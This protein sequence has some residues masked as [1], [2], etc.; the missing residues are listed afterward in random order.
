LRDRELITIGPLRA[1]IEITASGSAKG[2]AHESL[3][4]IGPLMVGELLECTAVPELR[5]QAA[6][7]AGQALAR[8]KSLHQPSLL[9][10]HIGEYI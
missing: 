3:F 7:V 10:T 2:L 1:G 8:L 5:A 4:P 6:Q 9:N